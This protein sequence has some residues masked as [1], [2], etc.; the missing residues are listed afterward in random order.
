VS[1]NARRIVFLV[2]FVCSAIATALVLNAALFIALA[3]NDDSGFEPTEC[4]YESVECGGLM[5]FVYDDTW[6][7]VG[8]LLLV[9]GALVGLA[10][11]RIVGR[12]VG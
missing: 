12:K 3:A 1:R 5:E 6:P 2:A 9:P 4:S 8:F 7:L 11:A 10:V